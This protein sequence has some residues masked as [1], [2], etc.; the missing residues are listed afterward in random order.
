M[1]SGDGSRALL[2]VDFFAVDTAWLSQSYVL[3][4]IEEKSR[5]VRVLGVTRHPDGVWATQVARDFVSDFEDKGRPFK[6][7]GPGPRLGPHADSRPR[8]P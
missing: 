8:V 3:F 7:L 2:A 4:G 6:V 5:A 1:S